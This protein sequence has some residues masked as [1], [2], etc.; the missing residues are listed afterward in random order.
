MTGTETT[1][2]NVK[3]LLE[4]VTGMEVGTL[5]VA[6]VTG[7]PVVNV[8]WLPDTVTGTDTTG[9]CG[10]VSEGL[11]GFGSVM[12]AR[13]VKVVPLLEIVMGTDTTGNTL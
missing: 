10:R 5:F 11:L 9:K 13:A 8:V 3:P 2:V 1:A 12:G 7:T 4:K 6:A